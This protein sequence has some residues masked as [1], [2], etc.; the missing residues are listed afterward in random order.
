MARR[1]PLVQSAERLIEEEDLRPVD[2]RAGERHALLL[3]AGELPRVAVG[4][5]LEPDQAQRLLRSGADHLGRLFLHP[6]TERHVLPDGHV[7]EEGVVLED[8]VDVPSFREDAVQALAVQDDLAGRGLL[9]PCDE[10]EEGGLTAPRRAEDAEVLAAGE[11]FADPANCC[12]VAEPLVQS[13]D[14]KNR[15]GVG[16]RH[17]LATKVWS[18]RYFYRLPTGALLELQARSRKD[19]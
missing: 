13:R 12:Q 7:G 19:R 1:R 18:E 16:A 11:R 14:L 10:A 2:E 15:R 3:A 6:Q 8:D 9:E 4:L 17:R 5:L